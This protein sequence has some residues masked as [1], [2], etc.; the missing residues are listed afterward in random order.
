MGRRVCSR[1]DRPLAVVAD[2]GPFAQTQIGPV[3]VELRLGKALYSS[4]ELVEATF[5]LT[6]H[7]PQ[8]QSFKFPSGQAYDVVVLR[9]GQRIWKVV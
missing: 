1:F 9:E 5:A 2:V 7:G 3:G 4:G 6:N 8:P